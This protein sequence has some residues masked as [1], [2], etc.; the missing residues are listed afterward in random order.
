MRREK[1]V[2]LYIYVYIHSLYVHSLH[3]L[4]AEYQY[5]VVDPVDGFD[6]DEEQ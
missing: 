4:M 5:Q 6:F 2:T 1:P 3:T